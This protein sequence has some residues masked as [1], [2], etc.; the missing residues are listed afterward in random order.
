MPTKI[1]KQGTNN[2]FKKM[3]QLFR[4]LLQGTQQSV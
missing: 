4:K 2:N 1:P 3:Q